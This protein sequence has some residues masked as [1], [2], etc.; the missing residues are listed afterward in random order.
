MVRRVLTRSLFVALALAGILTTSSYAGK[1]HAY[2][3]RTPSGAVASAEGWSGSIEKQI[4]SDDYTIDSCAEGGAL[5]SAFGETTKH[6]SY[7][8]ALWTFTT[9]S[10]ATLTSATLWR[11]TQL[12]FRSGEEGAYQSGLS[13][14]T[15]TQLFDQCDGGSECLHQGVIGE[16]FAS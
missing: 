4:R 5:I 14:P 11:A 9:P 10:F 1:Y 16:P 12:S 7:E 13:G 3:C 2:T 8:E 6:D 15:K